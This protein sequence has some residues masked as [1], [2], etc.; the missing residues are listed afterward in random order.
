MQG[1]VQ[2]QQQEKWAA[3]LVCFFLSSGVLGW[4]PARACQSCGPLLRGEIEFRPSSALFC[5]TERQEC[6]AQCQVHPTDKLHDVC[7]SDLNQSQILVTARQPGLFAVPLVLQQGVL[8]NFGREEWFST[9]RHG[10]LPVITISAPK[11]TDMRQL[12]TR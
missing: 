8:F 12:E 4:C 2:P 7:P 9:D 10:Q 1:Q 5:K 11:Q 3:Q 6:C